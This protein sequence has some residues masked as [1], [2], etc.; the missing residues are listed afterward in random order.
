MDRDQVTTK[1]CA[2][3]LKT[4]FATVQRKNL[5]GNLMH[6]IKNKE[7]IKNRF[8]ENDHQGK[9]QESKNVA[10]K[11]QLDHKKVELKSPLSRK[12]IVRKPQLSRSRK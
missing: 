10:A 2:L 12:K 11:S 9:S 8:T 3:C 4:C 5:L 1:H 7:Q 6:I